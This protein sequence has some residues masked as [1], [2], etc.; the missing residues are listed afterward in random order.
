MNR[1]HRIRGVVGTVGVAAALW[2]VAVPLLGHRLTV[3]GEPPGREG[4]EIGLAPVVI[5]ALA[6]ALA[7]WALLQ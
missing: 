5:V 1:R 3:T 7:G 4:L 6:A 2:T